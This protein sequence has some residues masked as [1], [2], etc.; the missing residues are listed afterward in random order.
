MVDTLSILGHLPENV[1][2]P[3]SVAALLVLVLYSIC[4]T[5]LR[6]PIFQRVGRKGT[7]SI[8]S[9]I[10]DRICLTDGSTGL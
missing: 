6:L 9:A 2:T 8:V 5:I 7:L 10:L 4:P 3:L 1:R